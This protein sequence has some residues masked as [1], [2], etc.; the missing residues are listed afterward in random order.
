ME[1]SLPTTNSHEPRTYGPH[2]PLLE[3]SSG[4][5]N[6]TQPPTP[7][8]NK[9]K[10]PP[11]PPQQPR[12]PTPPQAR[13]FTPQPQHGLM[14]PLTAPPQQLQS[15]RG[16]GHQNLRGTGNWRGTGQSPQQRRRQRGG[17]GRGGFRGRGRGYRGGNRYDI[18]K[19]SNIKIILSTGEGDITLIAPV[20]EATMT[21]MKG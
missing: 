4:A 21:I 17:R 20:Q 3:A 19:L 12:P 8:P 1:V 11:T 10:L 16:T 6:A 15:W 18:T 5:S 14:R 2:T 13:P 7:P 9:K